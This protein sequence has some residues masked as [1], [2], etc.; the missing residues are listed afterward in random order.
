M[1]PALRLPARRPALRTDIGTNADVFPQGI[2]TGI[3]AGRSAH[4]IIPAR[5][6][7]SLSAPNRANVQFIRLSGVKNKAVKN[8]K[9]PRVGRQGRGYGRRR[10]IENT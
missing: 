3:V 1:F 10:P 5:E 4:R 2:N 7:P 6:P 9:G 8:I